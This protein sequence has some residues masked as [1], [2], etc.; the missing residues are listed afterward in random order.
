MARAGSA[1][2]RMA[3]DDAAFA[4]CLQQAGRARTLHERRVL[5]RRLDAADVLR[6]VDGF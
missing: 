4:P 3:P 5:R 1:A 6:Q 2:S